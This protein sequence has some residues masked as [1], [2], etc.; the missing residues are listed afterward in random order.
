MNIIILARFQSFFQIIFVANEL[1][2]SSKRAIMFCHSEVYVTNKVSNYTS[3]S[4]E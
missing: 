2:A 3:A 4:W 1:A